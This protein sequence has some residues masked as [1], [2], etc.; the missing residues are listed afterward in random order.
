MSFHTNLTL[1]AHMYICAQTKI[2]PTERQNQND[3]IMTKLHE[4]VKTTE[5]GNRLRLSMYSDDN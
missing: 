5:R 2:R 4:D 1:Y 3:T